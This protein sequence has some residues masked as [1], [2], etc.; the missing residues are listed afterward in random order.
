QGDLGLFCATC[1]Q[2]GINVDLTEDLDHWRYTCMLVMDGNFKAEHMHDRHPA[3]QVWLMDSCRYMVTDLEY[4]AYLKDTPHIAEKSACNNHKAI[5][6]ANAQ[7]GRLHSMG[8]GAIACARHGCFYPHSVVDFQKGK[9][10]LNMDYSLANALS[11]NMAGLNH[12]L[13]F[14]DINCSY[15]TNLRM[16]V[17][18]STFIDIPNSMQIMPGI[19][20]W[21]VHSHKQECYACHAPLFMQG[22]GWVDGPRI[23]KI[24]NCMTQGM[25][26]VRAVRVYC[27]FH[28]IHRFTARARS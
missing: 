10:Q 5:S 23:E 2:P 20:I 3:D 14:Y 9:R 25:L 1:P 4:W 22:A 16:Q 11:Y 18:N 7:W 13:C 26:I 15:M 17:G 24:G 27:R 12:V 21:H 19:G 28:H 6:Q 8:I